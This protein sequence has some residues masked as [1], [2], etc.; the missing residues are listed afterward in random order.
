MTQRLSLPLLFLGSIC[1][2][3]LPAYAQLDE[4]LA[5]EPGSELARPAVAQTAPSGIMS[6]VAGSGYFGDS[7]IPGPAL[8]AQLTMPQGL[9]VD[10]KGNFYISDPEQQVVYKVTAGKIAVYAGTGVGGFAGDGGPATKAKLDLPYGLALDSAGNLYIADQGNNRIRKVTASTGKISTVAGS[11]SS[12]PGFNEP[13]HVPRDGVAATSATLCDPSAVAVD[14]KGDLYIDD[15]NDNEIRMV[16]AKTGDIST[17]AGAYNRVGFAGDGSLAVNASL[18]YPEGMAI[19]TSGNI[20]IADTRN[21]AVRKVTAATG[22]INTVAGN[23]GYGCP[24]TPSPSGTPATSA[25]MGK[26]HS[27]AVDAAGDIFVTDKTYA[28][29]YLI[30][31][32]GQNLYTIAGI[33]LPSSNPYSTLYPAVSL[34]AGPGAYQLVDDAAGVT[35]DN[36]KTSPTYGSVFFASALDGMVFKI[37]EPGVPQSNVPT[38]TT[39]YVAGSSGPQKITITAPVAGSAIYYTLTGKVPTTTATKY[40]K[41]ITVKSSAVITAFAVKSG[42]LSQAAILPL[43][44]NPEPVFS[45][46]VITSGPGGTTPVTMTVPVT[47]GT[48]YFTTDGS[49]PTAGGP[50]VQK[51]TKSITAKNGEDVQAAYLPPPVTDF[52]GTVWQQWSPTM[53]SDFP[54]Q[55]P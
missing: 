18:R 32:K 15:F 34:N 20:Y 21:C 3:G 31:A 14:A 48:I 45:A 17:V 50:T 2:A 54:F 53:Q 46:T 1:A 30:D 49:D 36:N 8:G 43:V 9:V 11:S 44:M 39:A 40:T 51:Y 42:V 13:C 27:I 22:V 6:L 29:V 4:V 19:D 41:P 52:A 23:P 33:N 47:G 24:G 7:G 10:S 35:V 38:F 28:Y 25:A 26:P 55:L 12:V 37:A 16:S 5:G